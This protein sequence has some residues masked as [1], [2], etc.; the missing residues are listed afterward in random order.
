MH[1]FAAI[2]DSDGVVVDTVPL[3]FK[4]WKRMFNEYGREFTFEQYQQKVDGIP[5]KDGAKAV[6]TQL[7]DPEI[8]KACEIKQRY[9]LEY[10]DKGM[11]VYQSTV[12]FVKD[13]RSKGVKTA[14][15]SSSKNLPRIIRAGNLDGLWDTVINGHE[16]TRGKP[17]PQIFLMAAERMDTA[18]GRCV[19]F[20]DAVLGV[21]A[22]KNGKMACVGVDRHNDPKRL[23]KADMVVNDFSELD[24]DKIFKLMNK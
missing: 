8:E 7:S 6:L 14:L 10:L 1:L 19:V 12:G 3:H 2:F 17:D 16:I 20:E 9:F 24:Y 5:R 4:A 13:I 22:A 23:S 15:I 21:E 18:P 11:P